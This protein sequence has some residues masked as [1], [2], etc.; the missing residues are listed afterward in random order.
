MN[1]K[2]VQK[3]NRAA[4]AAV[5][6]AS[7][8]A[9]TMPYSVVKAD[10]PFS[11]VTTTNSHYDSIMKLYNRGIISG[12]E[13][14]TFRPSKE[15]TRGQAAKMLALTLGLD[16]H[17]VKNPKFKD[18]P[19]T[20]GYYPYIAALVEHGAIS[21][22]VDNTFRPGEVITRNQMAKII[23]KGFQFGETINLTHKF[24]DVSNKNANR[25]YIQTLVDLGITTGTSAITFS[26]NKAVTRAQLSSFLIRAEEANVY[27]AKVKEITKI[28]QTSG[29]TYIYLNGVKHTVNASLRDILNVK[30][31]ETLKGAHIEGTIVGSEIRT[32]NKIT[33]NAVGAQNN[34]LTFDGNGST[35]RGAVEITGNH[36]RFANWTVT[37]EV[38]IAPIQT[39]AFSNL[40]KPLT[41]KTIASLKV[42][43]DIIDWG[44]QTPPS[45]L[46]PGENDG[47]LIEIP[48]DNKP[49][50]PKMKTV[51]HD[52][53]FVNVKM[54]ALVIT[55]N[56]TKVRS[57]LDLAH[58]T[59][60]GYVREFELHTDIKELYIESDDNVTFYGVA[61]IEKLYKNSYKSVNLYADSV[62]QLIAVDNAN[63]WI[64]L[65]DYYY[66]DKFI[67]PPKTLPHDIF[68]DF[69]NDSDKIGDIKDPGGT[70][71]DRDPIENGIVP[72]WEPPV[73]TIK[74]AQTNLATVNVTVNSN[75]DGIVHYLVKREKDGEP[76]IR[77]IMQYTGPMGGTKAVSKG[78]D[79]IITVTDLKDQ[80]KYIIY[81]VAVD[82]AGNV[83]KKVSEAFE[84]TDAT[85]PTITPV[86]AEGL[87][88]GTRIKVTM[89][90]NEAGE[91]Y[92]YYDRLITQART[93]T[94]EEI[95]K[96]VEDQDAQAGKGTVTEAGPMDFRITGLSANTSY[97]V[98]VVMKDKAGNVMSEPVMVSAITSELDITE[99]YV[100]S[101][102]TLE[103]VDKYE[104]EFEVSEPLDPVTA[105]NINNYELS[106]TGI[107]NVN[108]QPITIKPENVIYREGETKVRI[109]IPSATGLVN[110]DTIELK[111]LPG[112]TDLAEN[113]FESQPIG[114]NTNPR[115]VAKYIHSDQIT[116][117]IENLKIDVNAT[118]D[119]AEYTF[120]ANKAGTFY[121]MI[122]S[123]DFDWTD[124]KPQDFY[125]DFT[126]NPT[127]G[128]DF[129]DTSKILDKG[130]RGGTNPVLVGDQPKIYLDVPI[131]RADP[132]KSYYLHIIMRD[133]S[134]NIS[135][136]IS[137][138]II[139]DTK[140]PFISNFKVIPHL[141]TGLSPGFDDSAKIT[142]ESSEIGKIYYK[143]IP[144]MEE[145]NGTW[146]THSEITR[147]EGIFA[148]NRVA[149]NNAAGNLDLSNDNNVKSLVSEIKS[150]WSKPSASGSNESSIVKGFNTITVNGLQKHTKYAFYVAVE[151]K[152]G[153]ITIFQG[154]PTNTS[155]YSETHLKGNVYT[156]GLRPR[157]YNIFKRALPFEFEDGVVKRINWNENAPDSI[158][159]KQI[160][161]DPNR[162]FKLTFSEALS[163]PNGIP[164]Y[165]EN[166][167]N[168]NLVLLELEKAIEK[169]T[170]ENSV[171]DIEWQ[172]LSK[173]KSY[174]G[175]SVVITF[176]KDIDFNVTLDFV[177][178]TSVVENPSS[179]SDLANNKFENNIFV[180]ALP[181]FGNIAKF[182]YYG[183]IGS[184]VSSELVS[185]ESIGGVKV[186]RYVDVVTEVGAN[187][188]YIADIYYVTTYREL[189]T[190]SE[191]QINDIVKAIDTNGLY[192]NANVVVYGKEPLPVGVI[193]ARQY[194]FDAEN[195]KSNSTDLGS[196]VVSSKFIEGQNIFIFTRDQY[197]NII[198]SVDKNGNRYI[199]MK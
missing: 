106:G 87:P 1:N 72:D 110:G 82:E 81:A 49:V 108:N 75:E 114:L 91:Y 124:I 151:D 43:S 136:I 149:L 51:E 61:D 55:A 107:K 129:S 197:G 60:G 69:I 174:E 119:R 50:L 29:V 67:I 143:A 8:A 122:V 68:N 168:N 83:S 5:L 39:Q 31:T 73:L 96:L 47:G 147:L 175:R 105:N 185:P 165:I 46:E 186:S 173:L 111:V 66:V 9:V 128:V 117:K 134:G 166:D 26:P 153:N 13:D 199:E 171:K 24:E 34:V 181:G 192:T 84:I 23:V 193:G 71:V 2:K 160:K 162:T 130:G 191:Q 78:Q 178:L 27:G 92:Y 80:E 20:S 4:V 180:D 11:D 19:T 89:N 3:L 164:P 88:G 30:N 12:F 127:P 145:V 123:D 104:F 179:L 42:A 22:Y 14:K 182:M 32:L 94:T 132:F 120:K 74:N 167:A 101:S 17:N 21:G 125:N 115:N 63:G 195:G 45:Q 35:Y 85:P 95:L 152:F 137:E 38:K 36:L 52:I 64:D 99:P 156:D 56:R 138:P 65:G 194:R 183:G 48:P 41:V 163:V 116:P 126:N 148:N 176:N 76:S 102:L 177:N 169:M 190:L 44:S 77:E 141:E 161:Y 150:S 139:E 15:V 121:Y 112:V 10:S 172:D 146:Q 187:T 70:D 196:T 133:R 170:G 57:N 53:Q 37:G 100:K 79:A 90:P 16:I 142:F 59:V 189:K 157:V 25:F 54:R 140:A 62:T 7:G 144:E 98:Y 188:E 113:P 6:A 58:V 154:N 33:F 135:N 109:R 103:D 86:S 97:V 158:G 184:L 131:S 198:W 155:G 40:Y 93:Y 159:D 18:V 118:G 28:E